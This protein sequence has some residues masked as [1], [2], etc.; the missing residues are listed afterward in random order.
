MR[1][2]TTLVELLA[3]ITVLAL[4]AGVTALS[5]RSPPQSQKAG[6]EDS[7][8]RLSGRA[9]TQGAILRARDQAG[10]PVLLLPDGRVVAQATGGA[11]GAR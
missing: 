5:L 3:V 7:I 4:C 9:V 2:G 8:S 1:T 11:G 6:V 10:F